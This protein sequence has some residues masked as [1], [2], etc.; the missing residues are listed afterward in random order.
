M[1]NSQAIT[2]IEALIRPH[3]K[4]FVP[5]S[6]ARD[7]FHGDAG[8]F[9]NANENPVYG[10]DYCRYPDSHQRTLRRALA[11]W[12]TPQLQGAGAIT[13][14]EV[15]VGSGSD[16]AIDLLVKVF[17][18]PGV[19]RIATCVP[20]YGMYGVAARAHGVEVQEVLLESDFSL[21]PAK[22]LQALDNSV[23]VLFLCSPNNPT[24]NL[25]D[26]SAIQEVLAGFPGI[27]VVDEAYVDFCQAG[28]HLPFL[29][30]YPRLV[31]L[32]T[33]SKAWGLAGIRLGVA[34]GH[35]RLVQALS[36]VKLPYNVGTPAQELAL[37]ALR[38]GERFSRSCQEV[39]RERERVAE[40][41]RG[42]PLVET[43]Y[44]SEANFLLVRFKQ[45]ARV[46]SYLEARGVI[47]RDRA[48]EPL[49]G[50][51]LRITIGTARENKKLLE[52]LSLFAASRDNGQE[53]KKEEAK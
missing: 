21:N 15:F 33:F 23:K 24:G 16:E 39:V 29:S 9:L 5:Y 20:S 43:V 4:G 35:K 26:K 48:R 27:C 31:V 42:S 10:S 12:F 1:N 13:E 32:R 50:G 38:Q 47:V 44:P 53:E 28:S 36:A 2:E 52:E 49:C 40:A 37:D 45:S 25:L 19:D 7:E 22:L 17:C 6:S 3:L 11:E 41:L 18:S 14:E 46:F 8:V 51:C 30:T 34:L